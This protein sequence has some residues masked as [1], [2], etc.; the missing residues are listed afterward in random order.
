[1][2]NDFTPDYKE[3]LDFLIVEVKSTKIKEII[4]K[5]YDLPQDVGELLL[6]SIED[7]VWNK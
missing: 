2:R 7:G 5:L 1:M 4:T 3:K 6:K